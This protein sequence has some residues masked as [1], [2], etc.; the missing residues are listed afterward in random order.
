MFNEVF[1]GLTLSEI[2]EGIFGTLTVPASN[3]DYIFREVFITVSPDGTNTTV[4]KDPFYGMVDFSWAT[5]STINKY[6]F[7][8][9]ETR[10][11]PGYNY[12]LSGSASTVL[13]HFNFDPASRS[14]MFANQDQL[15]DYNT[16]NT[17][18]K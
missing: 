13:Q 6:I 5:A 7:G 18:W 9:F 17:N 11:W 16:I 10:Q 2:P 12:R 3:A 14:E 4:L 15:T 1:N 8:M